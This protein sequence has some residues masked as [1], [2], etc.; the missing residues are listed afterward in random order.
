MLRDTHPLRFGPDDVPEEVMWF[1]LITRPWARPG[2]YSL[3]FAGVVLTSVA[4]RIVFRPEAAES[5]AHVST[6]RDLVG[7]T[8][9]VGV[10]RQTAANLPVTIHRCCR[11]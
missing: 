9:Y 10:G 6:E 5:E 1:R 4:N 11:R 2:P 7:Q 8:A 3:S